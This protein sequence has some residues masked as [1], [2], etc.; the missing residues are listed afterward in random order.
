MSATQGPELEGVG[1]SRLRTYRVGAVMIQ[2][3]RLQDSGRAL[4]SKL[5][6]CG[7]EMYRTTA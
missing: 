1:V 6:A 3:F 4:S 5:G 2:G 7:R